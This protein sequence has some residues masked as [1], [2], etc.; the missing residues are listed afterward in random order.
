MTVWQ[1]SILMKPALVLLFFCAVWTIRDVLR[2]LIPP[3]RVHDV[4]FKER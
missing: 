1:Q 2:K 4:L 3:G